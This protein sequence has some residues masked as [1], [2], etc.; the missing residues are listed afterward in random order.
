MDLLDDAQRYPVTTI[1]SVGA[2]AS[3]AASISGRSLSHLTI[4][5]ADPFAAPWT[6]VT[7]VFPHGGILHVMF[8]VIW[9]WQ[10]G[11]VIESRLGS[12]ATLI[13]ALL[14]A[15]FAS[16]SQLLAGGAPIGLSGVVYA[17]AAFAW[18][19]SRFDPKFR[20]VINNGTRDFFIVWFFFCIV[21]TKLGVLNIANSAHFG[22]AV[23]GLS[24]GLRRQWVAPLLVALLGTAVFMRVQSPQGANQMAWK[25]YLDEMRY[26][27]AE[28]VLREKI[29]DDPTNAHAYWNLGVALDRQ[30][31]RSE[32]DAALERAAILDPGE[33]RQELED[34][35]RLPR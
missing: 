7:T 15:A 17:F 29:E 3:F 30:G 22:G 21:A 35:R 14:S 5:Q 13:L 26:G 12:P 33:F 8:N 19:R 4:Q 16:A 10:L 23:I 1:L 31:R 34:L 2:I 25:Q 28:R 27:D 20:G 6:F 9:I 18:A 24:L 32:S 11:R